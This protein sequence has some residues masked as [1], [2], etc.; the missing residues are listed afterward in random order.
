MLECPWR[1]TRKAVVTDLLVPDTR[2]LVLEHGAEK[3]LVGFISYAVRYS[4]VFFIEYEWVEKE[5][6][7]HEYDDM[8]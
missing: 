2:V 4:G 6:A 3:Q 1:K 8:L 7:K 5:Y